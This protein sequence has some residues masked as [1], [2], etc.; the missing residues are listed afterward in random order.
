MIPI[1]LYMQLYLKHNYGAYLNSGISELNVPVLVVD[2]YIRSRQ[3][4]KS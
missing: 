2:Q 1:V 3:S 4:V